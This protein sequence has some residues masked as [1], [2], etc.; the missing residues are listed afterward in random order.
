MPGKS[1]RRSRVITSTVRYL[2]PVLADWA[3]A[4]FRAE[5][6]V[7]VQLVFD[8]AMFVSRQRCG[9]GPSRAMPPDKGMA[10]P[11]AVTTRSKRTVKARRSR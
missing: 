3:G 9:A 1:F 8:I 6:V 4:G 10:V 7:Q 5:P 2:L 11:R